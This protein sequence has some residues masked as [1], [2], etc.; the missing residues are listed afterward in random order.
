VWRRASERAALGSI[1]VL[2]FT[3]ASSEPDVALLGDG[4][5]QSLVNALAELPDLRVMSLSSVG[6]FK[7]KD[8]DPREVGRTLHVAA[9]L[10]GRLM[11]RAGQISVSVALADARDARHLWGRDY[12]RAAADVLSLQGELAREVG[13]ELRVK[14]TGTQ[15]ERLARPDTGD[16]EA[17]LLYL[18]GRH[19]RDLRTRDGLLKSISLYRQALDRDATYARAWAGIAEVYDVLGYSR[20]EPP[21]EAFAN[22]SEAASKALEIDPALGEAWAVRAHV[23]FRNEGEAAKAEQ[24]F[25]KAIALNPSNADAHHWYAHLLMAGHRLDEALVH[26]LKALE[27]DPLSAVMNLHMAEHHL[28]AGETE[29]ARQQL[30]KTLEMSPGF[31]RAHALHAVVLERLGRHAEELA[32]LEETARLVPDSCDALANLGVAYARDGRRAEARALLVRCDA[33]RAGR[34]V[35]PLSMAL[36]SHAIGDEERAATEL[37]AAVRGGEIPLVVSGRLDSLAKNPRY[38]KILEAG[39]PD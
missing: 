32:A 3:A 2:P 7:G 31:A 14:L 39:R 16:H 22:A 30:M 36:L 19:F 28:E 13:R 9:V 8:V 1:A 37:E 17:Y 25:Q 24:W 6:A 20:L 10:T 26:G 29:K 35:S 11:Q 21:K 33:L 34:Y 15:D 4:V 5:T 27:L 38:A 12:T 23:A 18:K